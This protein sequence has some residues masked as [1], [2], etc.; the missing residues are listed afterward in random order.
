VSDA[1][2]SSELNATESSVQVAHDA[3]FNSVTQLDADNE[4]D[5]EANEILNNTTCNRLDKMCIL[6]INFGVLKKFFERNSLERGGRL[7]KRAK[8]RKSR[9]TGKTRKIRKIKK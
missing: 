9:K 2:D 5:S 7:S 3:S 1:A 8:T 6:G 4:D